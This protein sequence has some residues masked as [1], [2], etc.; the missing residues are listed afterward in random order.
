[1]T[2]SG[3]ERLRAALAGRYRVGR[4][5]GEGGTATV[6]LADDLK[7][8]REVAI[9]VLRPE[10]SI[11]V[12]PDRFLREITITAGLTHPHILP[13]LD[14]GRA[15]GLLFYVMPF[16]EGESLR[17]RLRREKQLPLEE[18]LGVAREVGDALSF[19]HAHGVVHRDIKPGNILLSSGHAIVA[20]FGI[21]RAITAAGG[22]QLTQTALAVGTPVYMS[23]EQMTAESPVDGRSDIYSLGCVLYEMLAGEPPYTGRS[24]QAIMAKHLVTPVPSV[25]TL[26]ETIPDS[27]D[28][29]L[30]R[31]LSKVPADRFPT[32]TDFVEALGRAGVPPAGG[33]ASRIVRNVRSRLVGTLVIAGA[34]AWLILSF[35]PSESLA[36]SEGEWV[37][38]T[39]FDNATGDSVLDKSLDVAFTLALQQSPTIKL[40]SS[41]RIQETLRRMML[42][43]ATAITAGVG[44]EIA[45]REGIRYV[46]SPSV[47][48]IGG[49][50]T[51]GLVIHDPEIGEP[52]HTTVVQVNN[53]EELLSGLD[54]LGAHVRRTLGESRRAVRQQV[55]LR[56]VT[57]ASLPALR[58]FSLGVEAFARFGD[59]REARR[60]FENA[61]AIDSSF[62][63]AHAQL[64]A[65]ELEFFDRERGIEHLSRALSDAAR[66][67]DYEARMVRGLHADLVEDNH[68]LAESTYRSVAD[69]Y[70]NRPAPRNNL[71]WLF[72]R[73]GRYADAAAE[74]RVALDIDEGFNWVYGSL[75]RLQLHFL[76]MLDSAQVLARRQLARDEG[77]DWPWNHLGWTLLGE[78]SLEAA[79]TAFAQ[80]ASLNPGEP[81]HQRGLAHAARMLGRTA[82]ATGALSAA[83]EA[84]S[85]SVAT[86]YELGL[87]HRVAG[88]SSRAVLGFADARRVL[89]Q[90]L[91]TAPDDANGYALLSLVLTR[92]GEAAEAAEAA[93]LALVLEPQSDTAL[94]HLA[95]AAMAQGNRSDALD[96]LSR[97]VA[98]GFTDVLWMRANPDLEALRGDET[99]VELARTMIH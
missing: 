59:T 6:Y 11:A 91:D 76:G 72:W 46:L 57:T 56:D 18:A 43:P 47:A 89:E 94:F 20:D 64:G 68:E 32:A 92:L 50:Y 98:A 45:E 31:A 79:R 60:L 88:D 48:G 51:L 41:A 93:R 81:E 17:E 27:V 28:G 82:E 80:A 77:Y 99:F 67:T 36:Y 61:I 52:I 14:S 34:V 22:E 97:A 62:A 10:L 40:I 30:T 54:Q 90:R 8:G 26:R 71:G 16:I 87:L 78:D 5:I 66:L 13:L 39:E 70:P 74:Y 12:G 44:E 1:M 2:G 4:Q 33:R 35:W 58:Q 96:Y 42:D 69:V 63:A 85:T 38:L 3:E 9:K 49:R 7:H 75:N 21:A 95:R 86:M 73:Q 19:A 29:A 25:R 24:T 55:D 83:L 65:L 15:D 53:R 84:D 37:L 23:P